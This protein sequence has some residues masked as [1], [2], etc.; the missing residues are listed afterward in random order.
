[1]IFAADVS[2]TGC[3]RLYYDCLQK[4]I[5]SQNF[6]VKTFKIITVFY[7]RRYIELKVILTAAG[8]NLTKLDVI[9]E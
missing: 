8:I 6:D 4:I 9:K 3:I 5:Q 2:W 1:M 7:K